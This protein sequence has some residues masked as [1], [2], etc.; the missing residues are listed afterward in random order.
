MEFNRGM[1]G[2]LVVVLSLIASVGLGVVTN[3]ESKTV[4]KEVE[5]YVADI[6][7]A[8]ESGKQQSYADYNPSQNF[9]GYTNNSDPNI[10]AVDTVETTVANNYPMTRYGDSATS[11]TYTD[12]QNFTGSHKARTSQISW[13]GDMGTYWNSGSIGYG[14]Q[15]KVGMAINGPRTGPAKTQFTSEDIEVPNNVYSNAIPFSTL[16]SQCLTEGDGLLS[17]LTDVYITIPVTVMKTT[18]SVDG[19]PEIVIGGS[20]YVPG[21]SKEV[22]YA[23][24][25]VMIMPTN[26]SW[27]GTGS[28]PYTPQILTQVGESNSFTIQVHYD[29]AKNLINATINDNVQIITNG[30]PA[31]YSMY[32]TSSPGVYVERDAREISG[33]SSLVHRY[34]DAYVENIP[35]TTT[36]V[37]VKYI[38]DIHKTYMD[39]RYGVGIWDGDDISWTNGQKNGETSIAFSVWNETTKEFTDAGLTY[40]TTATLRYYETETTDT[41]TVT[42]NSG[43][44][45]VT[46]NG[47]TS[48]NIGTWKQIQLNI[49][50]VNGTL[51]AYPIPTWTNFNSY[52]IGETYVHIGTV[53]KADLRSISWAAT[54]SLRL[55]V[56]NTKV[57]FNSYGVVMID[58]HIIISDLWPNYQRFKLD[59]SK[60]ATIGDSITIGDS[61][62]KI[63]DTQLTVE[64]TNE[65]DE[66]EYEPIG[67]DVTD[68]DMYYYQS[69]GQWNVTLVSGKN[70]Y[71]LTVPNTSISLNG[72]WYFTTGFFSLV[73]KDVQERTWDPASYN[74]FKGHVFFWMAGFVLLL[75][76]LA[77]KMGYLDGLS[78]LILIATEFILVIIGG[79]T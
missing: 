56:T 27:I 76:I 6:T 30:N 73:Y 70:T 43:Y 38:E 55:E 74:W 78:I 77:Y 72:L 20:P 17:N 39:P 42:R 23:S 29:R 50:N 46:L 7:G 68:M 64:T 34:Y 8:F 79:V 5:N 47:G 18:I 12:M 11:S 19:Y 2:V 25:N 62:F 69:E 49:D 63:V 1:V 75:G 36:N 60:V 4:T 24:N 67:I 13:Y 59:F 52:S 44:T 53:T 66:I 16:I 22:L 37:Q 51:V 40:T 21:P 33:D 54:N 26:G 15:A 71:D 32:F 58:P 9:I 3:I 31:N 28:Y 14:Y 41:I 48:I 57:F 10:Y 35:T 45:Y 61:T 65:D